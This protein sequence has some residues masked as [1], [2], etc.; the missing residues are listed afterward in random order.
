MLLPYGARPY[1]YYI[2]SINNCDSLSLISQHFISLRVRL[3]RLLLNRD[4][5]AR[6]MSNVHFWMSSVDRQFFMD[7][8]VVEQ[9]ACK[10]TG[11][12]R[13]TDRGTRPSSMIVYSYTLKHTHLKATTGFFIYWLNEQLMESF[14][15][16]QNSISWICFNSLCHCDAIKQHA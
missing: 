14:S 11:S 4:R 15:A 7:F 8:S 16:Y 12:D 9:R 6:A 13:K 2:C 1:L 3:C 10:H 5:S